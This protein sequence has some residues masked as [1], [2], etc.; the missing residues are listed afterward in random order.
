MTKKQLLMKY[1]TVQNNTKKIPVG[2]GFSVPLQTGRGAYPD[3]YA[4]N[5]GSFLG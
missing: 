4:K 5:T 3:S 2:A 1:N